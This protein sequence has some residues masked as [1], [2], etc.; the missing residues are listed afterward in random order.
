MQDANKAIAEMTECGV[1]GVSHGSAVVVEGS[2]SGRST[3]G[4]EGPEID[5]VGESF[6]AGKACHDDPFGS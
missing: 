1:M 4:G 3:E 2:S 5:G 6:V